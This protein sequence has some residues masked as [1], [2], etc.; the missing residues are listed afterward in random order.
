MIEK[1]LSYSGL[2]VFIES[3]GLLITEE[4]CEKL[5]K[6]VDEAPERSNNWQKVMIAISLDAFSVQTYCKL[7]EGCSEQDFSKAVNAVT[8]LQNAIPGMVYP[9]FVRM[10]DN[11]S[12]LEGFFRYWNEK[13]NPSTG[14]FIIQKYDNFAGLLPERKPADLSPL[15]RMPCWHLR[16]DLTILSNGDAQICRAHVLSG[17]I[18]NVFKD[19]LEN[20][21]HK[22]D[23][24]L[25]NHIEKNYKEKCERCD[26]SYTFNF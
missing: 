4:F 5:K 6:I 22:T 24:L 18:G 12:E 25:K 14:N 3:D 7:H 8:L 13:T 17:V 11:E 2:S 20:I 23:Y 1:V 15:E 16:R 19:D 26:E 10:D 21:W 9:Q